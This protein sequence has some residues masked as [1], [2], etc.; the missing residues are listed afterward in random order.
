MKHSKDEI[1]ADLLDALK[2][3]HYYVI[4][5]MEDLE[6]D[7]SPETDEDYQEVLKDDA[8]CRAAIAKA[9]GEA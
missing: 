9:E 4:W 8:L 2:E 3:V 7:S 5:T 6:R 1:I